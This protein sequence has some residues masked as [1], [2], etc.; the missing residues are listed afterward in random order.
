[1]GH[2]L[3]TPGVVQLAQYNHSTNDVIAIDSNWLLQDRV[4]C[5][6]ARGFELNSKILKGIQAV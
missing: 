3:C 1:M 4:R 6:C 2:I 5:A